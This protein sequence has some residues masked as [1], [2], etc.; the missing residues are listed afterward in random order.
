MLRTKEGDAAR[1][2]ATGDPIIRTVLEGRIKNQ[3]VYVKHHFFK[4]R[5]LDI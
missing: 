3:A 4:N 1:P 2:D 5:D